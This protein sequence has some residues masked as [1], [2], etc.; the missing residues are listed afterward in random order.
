M[1]Y[2]SKLKQ[3]YLQLPDGVK[4]IVSLIPPSVLLGKYYREQCRFLEMSSEWSGK[5]LA[6]YQKTSLFDIVE[7]AATTVPYYRDLFLKLG[8]SSRLHSIEEFQC[9]PY[10]TKEIVLEEK[11][12]MLSDAVPLKSRYKVTTGGTS[13][14]PLE[15]WMSSEAYAKEWA[16]VHDL[17]RRFDIE[18]TDRKIGLRGVP[19]LRASEGV[20]SQLNPVYR[21]LQLSPFHLTEEIVNSLKT[22]ISEFKPKYIHGY[23]SAVSELARLATEGAWGRSLKLKGVLVISESLFPFQ[24]ELISDAFGCS[25]FSF[26]GQTERLVFAGNAPGISGYLVDPRYGYAEDLEGELIGTGFLNRAMPMLRYRTGDKVKIDTTINPNLNGIISFPRISEIEGRWLQE[27][28]VGKNKTLI[29]VTA[30]NMHSDLFKN[31][32]RFQYRQQHAGKLTLVVVPKSDYRND[33]DP[34]K[35]NNAFKDKVGTEI[36]LQIIESDE[37]PLTNRG[38]HRF[39]IQEIDLANKRVQ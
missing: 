21:E 19:F 33:V 13:G 37:I 35:I 28:V 4:N 15:F 23:P 18:P 3:L 9:I 31:V 12:R 5:E 25:V 11:E 38:K 27:M 7:F 1:K 34:I 8:L 2:L 29:S 16:F 30:L 36:D 17:N 10:L 32:L 20:Y 24:E 6:D 26:Y 14:T 22:E 39:L